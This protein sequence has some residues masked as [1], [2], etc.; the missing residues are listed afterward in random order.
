LFFTQNIGKMKI[1]VLVHKDVKSGYWAEVPSLPG[2]Y[3]Q[4]ESVEELVPNIQ[5]A[6]EGYLRVRE[7]EKLKTKESVDFINNP[8]NTVLELVV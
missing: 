2:C 3:T 1:K 6:V 7:E 5:E 4:A 8:E